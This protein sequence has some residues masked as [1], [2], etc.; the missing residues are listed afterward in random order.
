M[1]APQ[2]PPTAAFVVRLAGLST[3]S[4]FHS[5]VLTAAEMLAGT[6]NACFDCLQTMLITPLHDQEG[7][8]A[9]MSTRLVHPW[10]CGVPVQKGLSEKRVYITQH[11][12]CLSKS[13]K[14]MHIGLLVGK[15]S[16]ARGWCKASTW[17]KVGY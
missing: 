9:R 5:S 8:V 7:L 3:V 11:T 2:P 4:G 14:C 16:A 15:I 1:G 12:Y 13:S 10:G 6:Y 17:Q